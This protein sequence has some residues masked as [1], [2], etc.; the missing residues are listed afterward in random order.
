MPEASP[1]DIFFL[2]TTEVIA[3][4]RAIQL[5]ERASQRSAPVYMYKVDYKMP[6]HGDKYK[7]PHCM[8]EPLYF[9]KA[10]AAPSIFGIN[11]TEAEQLGDKMSSAWAAFAR[12]GNPNTRQLPHWSAYDLVTRQTMIFDGKCRVVS[13]PNGKI[14][15]LFDHRKA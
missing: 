13:D 12:T 15:Q 1:S 2:L 4:R 6:M 11:N 9:G 14:R 7:S 8:D 10:D 3:R 5:A